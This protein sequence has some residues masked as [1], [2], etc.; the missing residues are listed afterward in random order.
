MPHLAG[1]LRAAT[2]AALMGC[3]VLAGAATARADP[4]AS[5]ADLNTL[6]AALSKGYGLNNCTPQNIV[7]GELAALVCGQSPDPSGPVQG[8]YI[9]F[10]N[11]DNLAAVFKNSINDDVLTACGD[12][13]QSPTVWHQ[14]NSTAKAGSI[15]CGTYQNGAEIIWTNDAKNVLNLIRAANTDVPALFQWW[16]ANG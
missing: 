12:Q 11:G 15:A 6:A 13:G 7:P 16:H 5:S 8:K 3:V 10:A 1:P 2:A 9:L 4:T 14:G